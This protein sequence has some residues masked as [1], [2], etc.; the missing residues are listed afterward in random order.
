MKQAIVSPGASGVSCYSSTYFLWLD[1][2]QA[3]IAARGHGRGGR[4]RGGRIGGRGRLLSTI[5]T[6][7]AIGKMK[8][9]QRRAMIAH[10]C[11]SA[12]IG[13]GHRTLV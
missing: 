6:M 1:D 7:S 10:Q 4:A 13:G 9:R 3:A 11:A 5:A 8:E 12:V 2:A